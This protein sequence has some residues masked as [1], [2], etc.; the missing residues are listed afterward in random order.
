MES[1]VSW[2]EAVLISK[3]HYPNAEKSTILYFAKQIY[4]ARYKANP[5]KQ[6]E[7]IEKPVRKLKE[8]Y[9]LQG[10]SI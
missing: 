9:I 1:G 4:A 2:Q 3:L 8:R 7:K 6:A 5:N 10:A